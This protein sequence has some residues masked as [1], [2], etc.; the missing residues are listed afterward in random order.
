MHMLFCG[1]F[2]WSCMSKGVFTQP[3]LRMPKEIVQM[4]CSIEAQLNFAV[5]VSK[6]LFNYLYYLLIPY[7]NSVHVHIH[8]YN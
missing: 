1:V 2:S 6:F 5:V 7:F 8:V 3:A 4:K